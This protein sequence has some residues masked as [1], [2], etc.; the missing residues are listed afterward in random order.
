MWYVDSC[1]FNVSDVRKVRLLETSCMVLLAWY[2]V[3]LNE[4][5]KDP[6]IASSANRE[7]LPKQVL[8]KHRLTSGSPRLVK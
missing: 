5:L 8:Q 3:S 7:V 1:H 6:A 4:P 2:F